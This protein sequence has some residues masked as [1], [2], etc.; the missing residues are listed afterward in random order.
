MN[1]RVSEMNNLWAFKLADLERRDPGLGALWYV[2]NDIKCGFNMMAVLFNWLFWEA[3][4]DPATV[5]LSIRTDEDNWR[6]LFLLALAKTIGD[7]SPNF[8]SL[9]RAQCT[10]LHRMYTLTGY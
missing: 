10:R 6:T 8:D 2:F 9:Q 5:L 3:F 1:K 7:R 4:P